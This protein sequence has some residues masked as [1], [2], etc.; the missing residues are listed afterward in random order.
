VRTKKPMFLA[1]FHHSG[2]KYEYHG[3]LGRS[4]MMI[5]RGARWV[6]PSR[7]QNREGPGPITAARVVTGGGSPAREKSLIRGGVLGLLRGREWVL[8]WRVIRREAES[9]VQ[10][11]P[12]SGVVL[13][14]AVRAH[15]TCHWPASRE[16]R[17][18]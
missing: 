15:T 6:R 9:R 7:R 13:A 11:R 5:P 16:I 18:V 4:A 17:C 1:K 10:G 2:R 14:Q 12:W 8:E 3:V